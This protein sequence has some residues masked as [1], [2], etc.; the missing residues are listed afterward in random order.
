MI[1]SRP[2]DLGGIINETIRIIK[3]TYWRAAIVLLVFLIPGLIL[4]NVGVDEIID[5]S[6]GLVTKFTTISPDAP[7]LFS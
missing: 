7:T 1:P 4:I 6:Q 3:L 5:E 2:L